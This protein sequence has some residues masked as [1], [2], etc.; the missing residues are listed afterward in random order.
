MVPNAG[1]APSRR[2][3]PVAFLVLAAVLLL[4]ANGSIGCTKVTVAGVMVVFETDGTLDPDTLHVT[5]T[6]GAGKTLRDWCYSIPPAA[7]P[8]FFPTTHGIASDGDPEASVTISASVLRAGVTLDVR[9]YFVTQVP[10]DHLVELPIL[11]SGPCI[12]QVSSV[13][14]PAHGENCAFSVA[15]S[16]CGADET[17]GGQT[18]MCVSD[19]VSGTTLPPYSPPAVGSS[20]SI[21][22]GNDGRDGAA[23]AADD[24]SAAT[25]GAASSPEAS[26]ADAAE[27]GGQGPEPHCAPGGPGLTNCGS[28]EE[29][30]CTN[31]EVTG[32][33]F[34]R[35]YDL[36]PQGG[37]LDFVAPDGGVATGLAA[38]ATVSRFRLDKYHVTVGRFRQFV[39]AWDGGAGFTP[40]AGSG[41][42]AHLN[43]G[44]GLV[45]VGAPADAGTVYETGWNASDSSSIAPTDANLAC[46]PYATW[47]VDV[48]SHENLPINCVSWL[49]AYAFCIWDEGFLPSEA[50]WGYAAAGGNQQRM[51][52]WGS[53]DPGTGSK[54]AIYGCYYPSGPPGFFCSGLSNIAPVGTVPG[55]AGLFGQLDLAGELRQWTLDW[56]SGYGPSNADGSVAVCTDCADLTSSYG[57]VIRGGDYAEDDLTLLAP[58]RDFFYAGEA[59]NRDPGVG[60]RCARS[61]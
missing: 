56:F 15:A 9:Q 26:P 40:P 46:D 31:Y 44:E 3:Q 53:D 45:D 39:E 41:K 12:V 18:G 27:A 21:G 22:L 6:S 29:S 7:E 57:R 38:P 34:Y 50:E 59:G 47:T 58:Y 51:Y 61:P 24:S 52:P 54:H 55:G 2:L 30:C 35:T 60:F 19:V 4:V 8:P 48:G 10:T 23:E 17:C 16:R 33:A 25:E 42:H 36:D 20:G 5:V 13:T 1:R 49:E 32:G 28:N 43:G 11:F 37:G 14:S